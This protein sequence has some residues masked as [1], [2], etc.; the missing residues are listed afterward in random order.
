MAKFDNTNK[1][2]LKVPLGSLYDS[3]N[4]RQDYNQDEINQLAQSILKN[5]LLNPI[6]VKAG[7]E[8]DD[9]SKTYEI[10]AGH[11]RYL[12]LVQLCKQGFD[13]GLVEVCIRNGDKWT[14]Q[15][16]ENIQ[17]TDLSP[18]EKEMAIREMLDKGLSQKEIA[19][20]LSKPISYVSDIIAGS[21][22]RQIAE[23]AGVNTQNISTRALA[24]LRS[25][26][27]KELPETVQKLSSSGGSN[28][29]ATALL[30]ERKQK[31]TA[32]VEYNQNKTLL[33]TIFDLV[34]AKT[35]IKRIVIKSKDKTLPVKSFRFD[36]ETK[37]ILIEV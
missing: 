10:I 5:G 29:V 8:N 21:K 34:N 37:N 14:L 23:E 11:R 32:N 35:E 19:E 28:A 33:E 13:F 1:T 4:V 20:M 24:Q 15:M 9:G 25:F 22:V 27:S 3:G 2:F 12:A 31:Q 16:I 26:D 17:R 30:H 6:T 18:Q 7:F 36:Q